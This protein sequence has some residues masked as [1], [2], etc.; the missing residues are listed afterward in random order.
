MIAFVLVMVVGTSFLL[1]SKL[2]ANLIQRENVE[3]TYRSL[4]RAKQALIAF[5]LTV[6]ERSAAV[7]RPGPGYLPCPD[8]DND[9]DAEGACGGGLAVPIGRLPYETLE[10]ERLLDDSGQPLWY[11]LSPNFRNIA[12]RYTPLNSE[13]TDA[14]PGVQMLTLDN[15]ITDVVAVIIAPGPGLGN[16]QRQLAPNLVT[17]YLENDN[18]N[19]DASFISGLINDNGLTFNDRVIAITRQELMAAVEKRVLAE[20]NL[21]MTN[22]RN[23]FGAGN[24]SLPWL[25]PFNDPSLSTYTG[26][27]GTWNGHLPIHNVGQAYNSGAVT[28]TWSNLTGGVYSNQTGTVPDDSCF[29]N[30]ACTEDPLIEPFTAPLTMDDPFTC[31]WSNANAFNCTGTATVSRDYCW[32]SGLLCVIISQTLVRTY[33]YSINTIDDGTHVTSSSDTNTEPRTRNFNTAGVP[34]PIS[35]S[36]SI[37][38]Q[39][40]IL[41]P[42]PICALIQLFLDPGWVCH[43]AGPRGGATLT[44][45]PGDTA[46]LLLTGID[47]HLDAVGIDQNADGDFVDAGIDANV[48]GDFFDAGDTPP[49]VPPDLPPWL[50][51]NQWH[52]QILLAY[53]GSEAVPGA[54]NAAAPGSGPGVCNIGADCL[55]MTATIGASVNQVDNRVRAVAIVAGQDLDAIDPRPNADITD[56]Y[57]QDNSDLDIT[58][59]RQLNSTLFNDQARV[60]LTTATQ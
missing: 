25:S 28:N 20:I 30:T 31:I 6:P 3:E 50:I 12:A 13:I 21:A 15:N 7:P 16:Q 44:L 43:V 18:S 41:V 46:D 33:T 55:T 59:D 58:Y 11:A 54:F 34:I 40:Q 49:D 17:N 22:Y 38:I 23:S 35:T 27:P 29:R 14:Q 4:E 48:D 47:F 37:D 10:E 8:L 60:L 26:V 52:W 39:D 5:A 45:N 36:L 1:V 57:D 32:P 19:G 53:P 56:Y 2:N 42:L 9:G 51:T 24:E